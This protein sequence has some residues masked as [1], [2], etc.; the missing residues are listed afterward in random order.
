MDVV[1][2]SPRL[3]GNVMR[4][5]A[6]SQSVFWKR[7]KIRGGRAM[8]GA[9]LK[10]LL[11]AVSPTASV[12]AF[13]DFPTLSTSLPDF[14]LSA[15]WEVDS[16]GKISMPF[17][18]SSPRMRKMFSTVAL[19]TAAKGTRRPKV[20]RVLGEMLL[21]RGTRALRPSATEQDAETATKYVFTRSEVVNGEDLLA[22][23]ELIPTLRD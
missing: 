16:A 4:G 7:S 18:I 21:R 9:A 14:S 5:R 23:A 15:I 6:F 12:A 3:T 1:R 13:F 8:M 17:R 2:M 10:T 20:M 22:L 19:A 11:A